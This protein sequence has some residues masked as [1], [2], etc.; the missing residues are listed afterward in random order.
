M[1]EAA[2]KEDHEARKEDQE[3]WVCKDFKERNNDFLLAATVK[4]QC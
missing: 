4:V 1:M 3:W 2:R